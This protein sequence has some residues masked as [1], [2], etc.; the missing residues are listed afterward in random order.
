MNFPVIIPSQFSN[1]LL[2]PAA[3]GP[4][5]QN[6]ELAKVVPATT[7]NDTLLSVLTQSLKTLGTLTGAA[8]APVISSFQ[9][10]LQ[11][12]AA[13]SSLLTR[14]SVASTLQGATAQNPASLTPLLLQTL[15]SEDSAN[16]SGEIPFIAPY[17][18]GL[19]ATTELASLVQTP[20]QASPTQPVASQNQDTTTSPDLTQTLN[21]LD[22]LAGTAD[23]VTL[24]VADPTS[25]SLFQ[26]HSGAMASNP[27][28]ASPSLSAGLTETPTTL[29]VME[30]YASE[31]TSAFSEGKPL[32]SNIYV[33]NTAAPG[34][35]SPNPSTGSAPVEGVAPTYSSQ[36][37]SVV[38]TT[39]IGTLLNLTG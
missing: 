15:S 7:T 18:L 28:L 3:K 2:L 22:T 14:P 23:A 29:R 17:Q 4:A 10:A 21:P 30:T 1:P 19:Q 13:V 38:P 5:A 8:E 12:N 32:N 9:S 39:Q 36:G 16:T 24:G 34:S 35:L 6:T 37:I 33:L 27:L 20:N 11:A 31:A 25:S 26:S